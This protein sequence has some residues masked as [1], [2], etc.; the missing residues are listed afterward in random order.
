MFLNNF[1]MQIVFDFINYYVQNID[2]KEY[3]FILIYIVNN[4]KYIFIQFYMYKFKR[5][6]NIEI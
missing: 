5:D 2:M 6:R 3:F 4:S 1:I